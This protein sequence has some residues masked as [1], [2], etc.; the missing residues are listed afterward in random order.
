MSL[1]AFIGDH[2]EEIISEFA[3]FAK[4]L[5]P[6]GTEMTDAELRDHAADILTAVVDD[7]GTPQTSNSSKSMLHQITCNC[8][9]LKDFWSK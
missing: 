7:V 2:H 3:V 5:M 4:T 1:S 9:V 6:A 8:W